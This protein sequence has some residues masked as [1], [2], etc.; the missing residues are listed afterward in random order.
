MSNN[1]VRLSGLIGIS[2]V[3]CFFMG[4]IVD[5][6][7]PPAGA[8]AST[9]L[10]HA[11]RYATNDRV[12]AFVFALGAAASLAFVAGLRQW[13]DMFGAERWLTTSMLTGAVTSASVIIATS[14]VWFT[15]AS[16]AAIVATVATTLSD[17]VNYG[18]VFAG[19]G[20]LLLVACA[21]ACML[22]IGGPFLYLG[23]FGAVVSALLVAY[24]LTAFFTS[25]PFGAG[26]AV[27]IIGFS[28]AAL[29]I[30]FASLS[31]LWFARLAAAAARA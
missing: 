25:G 2:A 3:V 24:V 28:V 1:Y 19:F 22:S 16:D 29:W 15:L 17:V 8:S 18:F 20:I 6:T 31:M 10:D 21:S 23:R 30:L 4:F 12:A 5:P 7:P 11:V 13:L 27:T 14:V 26:Q 9:V